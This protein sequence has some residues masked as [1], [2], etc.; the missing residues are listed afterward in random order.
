[1]MFQ[2]WV[3]LMATRGGFP[4]LTEAN[5]RPTSPYDDGYNCIAWAAGDAGNWWWP[6]PQSQVYWP[7]GAPREATMDAFIVAYG[8]SGYLARSDPNLEPG[9]GKVAVYALNGRP[10]HAARQL[11]DGWWA[12]KLGSDIDVEHEFD[13]LDGPV[14]GRPAVVLAKLP[15]GDRSG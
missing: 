5:C 10:T 7:P 11:P 1:M 8:L 3:V 9:V 6:D 12:S 14:Y 4:R 2:E 13:A 15:P